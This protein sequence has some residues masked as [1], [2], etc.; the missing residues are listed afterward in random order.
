MSTNTNVGAAGG[1]L[2][3]DFISILLD[4]VAGHPLVRI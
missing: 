4:V 2:A 3:I 1:G